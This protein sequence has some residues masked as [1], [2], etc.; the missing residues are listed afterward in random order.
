YLSDVPDIRNMPTCI[1]I[2][3]IMRFS[4]KWVGSVFNSYPVWVAFVLIWEPI[5]VSV[6]EA[7]GVAYEHHRNGRWTEAETLYG[8]I[9]HALPGNATALTLLGALLIDTG[10][11]EEAANRLQQVI[12]HDSNHI[13]ARYN[14]ALALG[15]MGRTDAAQTHYRAVLR[16]DPHHAPAHNNLGLQWRAAG[17]DEPAVDAF[18]A[19]VAAHPGFAEAWFNLGATWGNQGRST[20]AAAAL[21]RGL[22]I[23]PRLIAARD[24]L[25]RLRRATARR[26]RIES[27]LKTGTALIRADRTAEGLRALLDASMTAADPAP[28]PPDPNDPTLLFQTAV[29][30]RHDAPEAMRTFCRVNMA[31][32]PGHADANLLIGI[33]LSDSFRFFEAIQPLARAVRILPTDVQTNATLGRAL[34]QGGLAEA[35]IPP[36]AFAAAQ[37]GAA[38]D[39]HDDYLFALLAAPG[40][41]NPDGGSRLA[42][43]AEGRQPGP[44]GGAGVPSGAL[45]GPGRHARPPSLPWAR[46]HPRGPHGGLRRGG[47]GPRHVPLQLRKHGVRGA[48]DG[49]AGGHAGRRTLRRTDGMLNPQRR[50]VD[51]VGDAHAGGLRGVRDRPRVGSR[52]LAARSPG[53]ARSAAAVASA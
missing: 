2:R 20:K 47:R 44:A 52:R 19:A 25:D 14:L 18:R 4:T 43:A 37:P 23:N 11:L 28:D 30:L 29:A 39:I 32:F 41:G 27:C 24:H 34:F 50:R 31:L 26:E 3:W 12:A 13:D 8:R 10:R 35:A 7:L 21:E 40:I 16:I 46:P 1:S 9:L 33:A 38:G 42:P 6:S 17:R 51:G 48:V 15:R 53:S 49:G 36:L 22:A 45:R 5:M